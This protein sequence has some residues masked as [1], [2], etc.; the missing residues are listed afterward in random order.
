MCG[1]FALLLVG[2][3][4]AG[5]GFGTC[6]CGGMFGVLGFLRGLLEGCVCVY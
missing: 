3:L 1:V 4:L 6:V 5:T 2:D